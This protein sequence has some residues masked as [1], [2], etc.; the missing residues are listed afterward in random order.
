MR[1]LNFIIVMILALTLFSCKQLQKGWDDED[2]KKD[3]RSKKAQDLPDMNISKSVVIPG[4]GTAPIVGVD[5]SDRPD[6][7]L[8]FSSVGESFEVRNGQ[9]VNFIY[10]GVDPEDT[11]I[12]YE[13]TFDGY[14]LKLLKRDEIVDVEFKKLCQIYVVRAPELT[15][16][17]IPKNLKYEQI[18]WTPRADGTWEV[19]IGTTER[20]CKSQALKDLQRLRNKTYESNV[21]K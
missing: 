14:I 3:A 9:V 8:T 15:N 12:L 2:D 18:I 20:G 6:T 13:S 4:D 5:I 19:R 16:V 1:K 21:P 7:L 17:D 10:D 11:Y